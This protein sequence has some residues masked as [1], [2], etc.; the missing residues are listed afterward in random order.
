MESLLTHTLGRCE[1]T[2]NRYRAKKHSP[3]PNGIK[4]NG[5]AA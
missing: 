4:H 1:G 2:E 5:D 3:K